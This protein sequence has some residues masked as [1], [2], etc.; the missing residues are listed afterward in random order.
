M[1]ILSIRS[2]SKATLD[3]RVDDSIFVRHSVDPVDSLVKPLNCPV[4]TTSDSRFRVFEARSSTGLYDA[5]D[6]YLENSAFINY[7]ATCQTWS[8]GQC[9]E[10]HWLPERAGLTNQRLMQIMK[11][12]KRHTLSTKYEG[13]MFEIQWFIFYSSTTTDVLVMRSLDQRCT[14]AQSTSDQIA[15]GWHPADC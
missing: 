4:K 3:E 12:L 13:L 1:S 9:I 2:K 5:A 14:R 7:F 10:L 15:V 6:Q 11:P 8:G